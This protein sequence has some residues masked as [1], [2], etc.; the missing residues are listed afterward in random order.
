MMHGLGARG[1]VD[2][3]ATR[4]RVS[5]QGHTVLTD[6]QIQGHWRCTLGLSIDEHVGAR[7]LGLEDEPA[8]PD[9][10]LDR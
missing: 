2:R 5:S 9:L 10:R 6:V 8:G 3:E 7:R 4:L 1:D